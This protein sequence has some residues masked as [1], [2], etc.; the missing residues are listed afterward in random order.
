MPGRTLLVLG[1]GPGIGVAVA[2]AFSVRGFT[3]IALVS[4][5]KE[6]L[7]E[8]EDSVL[9]AIQERGYSCQVRTWQCDLSDLEALKKVL[10]EVERFGTLECVFFN[11]ARVAGKPPLEEGVE[12]IERD[13]KVRFHSFISG[14]DFPHR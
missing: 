5:N 9:D 2:R 12:D 1:S 4:R 11:A 10:G 3:H 7:A 6:R 8:D 14:E 13:F